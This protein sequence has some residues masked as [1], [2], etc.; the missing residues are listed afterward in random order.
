ME[1]TELLNEPTQQAHTDITDVIVDLQ[2]KD[3]QEFLD[4]VK[5]K[6]YHLVNWLKKEM[7]CRAYKGGKHNFKV[8]AKAARA[9]IGC[10]IITEDRAIQYT[11]TPLDRDTFDVTFKINPENISN[12]QIIFYNREF[13]LNLPLNKEVEVEDD[14]DNYDIKRD[15]NIISRGENLDEALS[16]F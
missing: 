10:G 3:Y 15:S 9:L 5:R 1:L 2:Q 14:F 6:S 13:E 8:S 12:G 7:I 4:K 11:I 16:N